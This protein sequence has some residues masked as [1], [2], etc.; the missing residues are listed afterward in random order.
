MIT[1]DKVTEIEGLCK[2]HWYNFSGL[3]HYTHLSQ[4][5]KICEQ[6]IQ[7]NS[8]RRKGNHG[9]TSSWVL[10]SSVVYNTIDA[11]LS[12][13]ILFSTIFVVLYKFAYKYAH[14][15]KITLAK[16]SLGRNSV[17]EYELPVMERERYS[18]LL[19]PRR[20]LQVTLNSYFCVLY[21]KAASEKKENFSE[22]SG[23]WRHS[24][25]TDNCHSPGCK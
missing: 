18:R 10:P 14:K 6:S 4:S 24:F 9:L 5:Q 11:P 23:E 8:Y 15:L 7:G 19:V 17:M 12:V 22:P 2:M 25:F 20:F 1:K 13:V 3:K 21:D 16:T